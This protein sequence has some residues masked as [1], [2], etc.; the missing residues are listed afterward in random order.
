MSASTACLMPM[1][2]PMADRSKSRV[3]TAAYQP[4]FSSPMTFSLG[5]RT[6]SK[7]ISLNSWVSARLV[8]GRTVMP[9]DFISTMK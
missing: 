1:A 7:N 2:L 4:R 6:L 5:T 9:G 8:S 3:V